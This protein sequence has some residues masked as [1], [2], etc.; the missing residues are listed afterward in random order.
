ML[1]RFVVDRAYNERFRA[2]FP[3]EASPVTLPNIVRAIASFERV[4]VS[5]DSA[6]DRY[7]YRDD[8]RRDVAGGKARRLALFLRSPEMQRMSRERQYF[9]SDD[10]HRY[11][12]V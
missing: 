9:R 3:D 7:L 10:V 2:A 4:L 12:A 5:A 8:H 1:E 11:D 6:F